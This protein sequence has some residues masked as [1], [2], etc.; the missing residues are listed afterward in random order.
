MDFSALI[1]EQLKGKEGFWREN[2]DGSY[3]MHDFSISCMYP[4]PEPQETNIGLDFITRLKCLEESIKKK[5]R[6]TSYNVKKIMKCCLC[7]KVIG[8]LIFEYNGYKWP[9]NYK[10]YLIDH[11]VHPSPEFIDFI[12]S[13]SCWGVEFSSAEG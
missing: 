4:F 2:E 6:G 1:N 13:I 3:D 8:N 11:Y 5:E 12:K 10:H 9:D 7:K